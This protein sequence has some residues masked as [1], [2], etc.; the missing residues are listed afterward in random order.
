MWRDVHLE[1]S[2]SMSMV[3]VAEKASGTYASYADT[4]IWIGSGSK[5]LDTVLKVVLMGENVHTREYDE[6][7]KKLEGMLV[8]LKFIATPKLEIL[9]SR[10][11]LPHLGDRLGWSP[12]IP[13]PSLFKYEE[14]RI[15]IAHK[16]LEAGG[17]TRSSAPKA[18]PGTRNV[19][20]RPMEF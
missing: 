2:A 10:P 4:S 5:G 18:A 15:I 3:D 1:G 8:G 7:L 16:I 6:K 14:E 20:T 19:A 17:R 9:C 13:Y 11:F 12:V